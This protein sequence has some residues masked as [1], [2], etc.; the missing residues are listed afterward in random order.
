MKKNYNNI[1]L[2][3][4]IFAVIVVAIHIHPFNMITNEPIKN[5]I[6]YIG[7][8]AVPFFMITTGFF[9]GKKKKENFDLEIK[10]LIKKTITLYLIFTIIY[11][12]LTI[13]GFHID[14]KTLIQSIFIFIRNLIFIGENYHSY[15]LWYLL[16]VIYGLIIIYLFYK[17]GF[18]I[19]KMII[20]GFLIYVIGVAIDVL[21]EFDF[22]KFDIFYKIIDITFKSGRIFASTLYMTLGILI[23]EEENIKI[24][25]DSIIF[26]IMIIITGFLGNIVLNK[27]TIPICSMII[28]ILILNINICDSKLCN[29]LRQQSTDIYFF[30]LYVWSIICLIKK[31]INCYGYKTFIITF[32]I[33]SFISLL[34]YYIKKRELERK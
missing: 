22:K 12:P 21:I 6:D 24:K 32:V 4:Y 5:F 8:L 26:L 13:Y 27:I 25:K 31:N 19:K 1:N 34:H 11:L 16:S 9:L 17:K 3:K 7:Y 20:S 15:I 14:G 23:S 29:L 18:D 33:T 28:F 2:F 10:K 30:H